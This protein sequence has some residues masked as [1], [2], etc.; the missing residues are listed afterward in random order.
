MSR[1]RGSRL[2][3]SRLPEVLGRCQSDG[4]QIFAAANSAEL[5][6]LN[7]KEAGDEGWF[8]TFSHM[9]F[10]VLQSDPY[11]PCGRNIARI[12]QIDVCRRPTPIQ[13]QFYEFL[14]FGNGYQKQFNCGG[15]PARCGERMGFDRG[16]FPTWRD[17]IPGHIVRVRATNPLDQQGNK[18]VLVQGMDNF[19]TQIYN[20]DAANNVQ[21]VFL[22]LSSPFSDTPMTL[23]SITGIQKDVTLGQVQFFDV[24]PSDGSEIP[25]L[26]ME[27]SETVGWYRRYFLRSLPKWCCPLVTD[28]AGTPLVQVE[29]IVKLEHVPVSVDTD[30]LILQNEEAIIS[31]AQS[32]RYSTMDTPAAKGMAAQAHKEAI[33]YLQGELAHYLGT[34]LP[35]ISFYPFGSASLERQ[36]IGTLI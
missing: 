6:L 3:E 32:M 25:I 27:P 28:G 23:N 35:A 15:R 24:N 19:K 21:G 11:I 20:L 18:R 14:R 8:G 22:T 36:R 13:N 16:G 10:N 4:P 1:I 12:E 26:I 17:L 2:R 29:A 7:A 34:E 5:R 31:E 9:L 33:G 30:Y